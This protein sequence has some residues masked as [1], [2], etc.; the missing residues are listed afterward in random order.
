MKNRVNGIQLVYIVI[1][2]VSLGSLAYTQSRG[3]RL[4]NVFS[5]GLKAHSGP[6]SIQHK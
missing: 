3:M 4:L 2:L 5:S 6:G 1:A